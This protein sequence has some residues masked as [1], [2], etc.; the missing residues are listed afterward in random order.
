[1]FAIVMFA[2]SVLINGIV[3]KYF[4]WAT[5]QIYTLMNRVEVHDIKLNAHEE[6]SKNQFEELR[7]RIE[8]HLNNH[9]K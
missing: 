8:Y 2:I 9:P 6:R 7:A 3:L 4:T 5:D 1:M